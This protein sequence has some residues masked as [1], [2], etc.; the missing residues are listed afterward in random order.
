[1][2]RACAKMIIFLAILASLTRFEIVFCVP[3]RAARSEFDDTYEAEVFT[4]SINPHDEN[5]YDFENGHS[6]EDFDEFSELGD[7]PDYSGMGKKMR[8]LFT[9]SFILKKLIYESN[10]ESQA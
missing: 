4:V 8:F 5:K 2:L 7:L 10:R 9:F 1:V 3:Q 6:H